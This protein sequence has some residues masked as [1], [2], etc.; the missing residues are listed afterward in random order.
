M[1]AKRK[2]FTAAEKVKLL[3]LHLVEKEPV[4]DVCDRHGLNLNV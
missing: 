3:R 4:S 2:R 1:D